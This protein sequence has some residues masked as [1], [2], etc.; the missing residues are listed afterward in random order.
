MHSYALI[1]VIG[2]ATLPFGLVA[3]LVFGV[4][5]YIAVPVA[6]L[7][8]LFPVFGSRWILMLRGWRTPGD[9]QQYKWGCDRPLW[10]VA[11]KPRP[12]VE[13]YFVTEALMGHLPPKAEVY[14][15]YGRDV[16]RA[17]RR[18]RDV[19][20]QVS[21]P[22]PDVALTAIAKAGIHDFNSVFDI[23]ESNP[24]QT[25]EDAIAIAIAVKEGI[26]IE[27]VRAMMH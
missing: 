8:M 14:E 26:P 19:N 11:L 23:L 2:A 25:T 22:F 17:F 5:L 6:I 1:P 3:T 13:Q 9:L 27:Y 7:V 10:T 20:I 4:P 21:G 18:A 24:N 12:Q 15:W 16:V